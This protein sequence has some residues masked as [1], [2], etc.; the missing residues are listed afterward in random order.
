MWEREISVFNN[1]NSL[2]L[3][4]KECLILNF[5]S[6]DDVVEAFEIFDTTS[7]YNLSVY[8]ILNY[9]VGISNIIMETFREQI[10]FMKIIGTSVAKS[11]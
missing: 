5:N 10:S 3:E 8:S 4:A 7:G 6:S 1:N 9:H 11:W 2:L